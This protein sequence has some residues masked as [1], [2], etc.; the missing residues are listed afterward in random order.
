[1]YLELQSSSKLLPSLY[2]LSLW[3]DFEAFPDLKRITD[4]PFVQ[5]MSL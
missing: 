2:F 1:M 4:S 3:I 5:M